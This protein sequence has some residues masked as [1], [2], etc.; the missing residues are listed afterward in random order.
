MPFDTQTAPTPTRSTGCG[1]GGGCDRCSTG[2]ATA[3]RPRFFAG[4]L[5][6]DADLTRLEEYVVAKD[7]LHNRYLVGTGV[8]CGL[9]VVCNPCDDTVTVRPGYALGPCGE[10]VVVPADTRVDVAALVR[11]QRRSTARIDCAPFKDMPASCEAAEQRWILGICYD[12]RPARPVATLRSSASCAGACGGSCGASGGSWGGSCSS[13]G[14]SSATGTGIATS[15]STSA[16]GM[17]AGCENTVTCEGFR[18]VLSPDTSTLTDRRRPVPD[19]ALTA[20]VKACLMSLTALVTPLPNDPS[21]N[22]VVTYCCTLRAELRDLLLRGEFSGCGLLERLAEVVCPELD[23]QEAVAKALRALR[24]MLDIVVDLYRECLCSALLP[25]CPDDC[26]DDCVPLATLTVRA[27]DL[28]VLDVCAWS[29]RRFA[30]TLPMLGYWLS[31]LPIGTALRQ[32]VSRVCCPPEEPR[33]FVVDDR[34]HVSPATGPVPPQGP[35]APQ[36]AAEGVPPEAAAPAAEGGGAGTASA[37]TGNNRQGD[38]AALPA[39]LQVLAG[40]AGGLAP[41]AGVEATV[42]AR[43]GGTDP[44]GRPAASEAE[45]AAPFAALAFARAGAPAGSQLAG[46]VGVPL[47]EAF[48]RAV[49]ADRPVPGSDEAAG[50]LPEPATEQATEQAAEQAAEQAD[51]LAALESTVARLERRVTAQARTI[52]ALRKAGGAQ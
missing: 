42:L 51:R 21:P 47:I 24:L 46:P 22:D 9:E 28:R 13:C 49:G 16:V 10:D 39:S 11:A 32:A 6:T 15:M 12:E 1:C 37:A 26:A 2:L 14:C 25:P 7:R 40:Y 41:W 35:E 36:A 27:S 18:F 45:L 8:V 33:R 5:L 48:R 44:Q 29:S 50:P 19:G 4:Q 34:L 30:V 43:M 52:T 38:L 31:W 17:P 20:R 3:C 23:D